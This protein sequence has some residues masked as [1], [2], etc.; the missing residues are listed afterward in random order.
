MRPPAKL[1]LDG[2]MSFAG[3]SLGKRAQSLSELRLRLKQRAARQEDVAEAIS[4]LKE[5]GFLN[6]RKFADSFASWRREN[7]GLGKARVMRDLMA[8][9]VAPAVAKQAV[10]AAY[11]SSDETALIENFLERKYR[12]KDLGQFLADEKN[13]ASAFRRLRTAGFSAGNSIRVL[14]RFAVAAERLDEIE[15]G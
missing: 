11:S 6:D 5:A 14:K 7:Q 2:L 1:D 10:D 4:R 3:R 9:R 15:E 8:R 13:L 12:G